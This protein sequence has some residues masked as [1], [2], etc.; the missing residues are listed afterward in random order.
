MQPKQ[1]H[2]NTVLSSTRVIIEQTFGYLKGRFRRLK[3][4]ESLD[5][6]LVSHTAVAAAVLPNICKT[7]GN[8]NTI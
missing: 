8:Q 1:K 3:E 2:F 6:T 4:I 7:S 5:Y